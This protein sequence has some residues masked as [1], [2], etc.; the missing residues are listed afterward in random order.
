MAIIPK[1][2]KEATAVIGLKDEDA[3]R[4]CASGFFVGRYEGVDENGV[5]KFS[6]YLITNKHVV[7]NLEE[8][9]VQ[10]N[11]G[12]ST[13]SY[14][15]KTE[16]DGKKVFS[17]H[18]KE[19]VDIV[20][21]NVDLNIANKEGAHTAFF[22]L[23]SHALDLNK[24]K[25]TDVCEGTIVYVLGYPVG[26]DEEL[27]DDIVKA[28]ICRLGCIAKI[29]H[30][31]HGSGKKNYIIDAEVYPGN[32]GGPVINRPENICIQ[33]TNK[34]ESVNLIGIIS[35]Y[36]PYQ[37]VLKSSQTGRPRMVNE[38]NSGLS[39]VYP[40]DLIKDVVEIERTRLY[41]KLSNE[42]LDGLTI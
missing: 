3:I 21:F 23:D 29:E 19:D 7:R 24:M 28:P 35:A 5:R 41:G 4:W 20:A 38:E 31:Y 15:V 37:E 13:K 6:T 9:A 2:M 36:L 14:I 40:V 16:I 42:T 18:P 27:V 34:N 30:L 8:F 17:G 39:I 12:E 22:E 26:I 1:F 10:F 33:G 11:Y 32:S 25:E